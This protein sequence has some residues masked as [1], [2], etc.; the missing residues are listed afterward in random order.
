MG[1]VVLVEISIWSGIGEV[2]CLGGLHRHEDL[3]QGKEARENAL[4]RILLD[5]VVGDTHGHAAFLQLHVNHR[6]AIDQED[7]VATPVV[8]E[9]R[10]TDI[11]RLLHDLLAALAGGDLVAVVNF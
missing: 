9:L 7:Q 2:K 4:A 11:A 8:E 6:H 10:T 5:L 3:D 1:G